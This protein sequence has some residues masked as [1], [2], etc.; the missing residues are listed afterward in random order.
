MDRAVALAEGC[1]GGEVV[2][3]VGDDAV[4][5]AV[6]PLL[7]SLS[8]AEVELRAAHACEPVVDCAPDELVGEAV[9]EA[10]RDRF[11]QSSALGRLER[12]EPVESR[13]RGPPE[14][15]QLNLRA[16]DGGKL[17]QGSCLPRQRGDATADDL[18]YALRRGDLLERACEP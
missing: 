2:S 4:R 12:V 8:D 3:E 13:R 7:E 15:L 18:A 10:W 11:D 6:S 9:G 17:E 16:G 1:R 14:Q 5:A